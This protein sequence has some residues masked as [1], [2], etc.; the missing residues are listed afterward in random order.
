MAEAFDSDDAARSGAEPAAGA[1]GGA[2]AAETLTDTQRRILAALCRPL[3]E[4]VSYATS[5]TNRQNAD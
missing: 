1:Q 5:V 2:P 4:G 3:E